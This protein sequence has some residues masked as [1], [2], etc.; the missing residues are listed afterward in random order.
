MT[1]YLTIENAHEGITNLMIKIQPGMEKELFTTL[2]DMEHSEQNV[3]I[4]AGKMTEAEEREVDI[5][6]VMYGDGCDREEAVAILDNP[7]C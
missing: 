7:S 6:S 1:R 2:E 4:R 5:K 3:V